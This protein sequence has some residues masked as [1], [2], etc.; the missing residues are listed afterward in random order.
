MKRESGVVNK[1]S[2]IA[3]TLEEGQPGGSVDFVEHGVL[4]T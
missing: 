2:R 3:V 1:L 4:P